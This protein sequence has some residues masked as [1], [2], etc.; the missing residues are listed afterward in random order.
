[1][2]IKIEEYN[3]HSIIQMWTLQQLDGI[4][5]SISCI[6]ILLYYYRKRPK[7]DSIYFNYLPKRDR[8]SH[9]FLPLNKHFIVGSLFKEIIPLNVI[10][11]K[12]I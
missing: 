10:D 1:M 3:A 8:Q 12:K 7:K 5:P 2:W 6:F 4:I 11:L 9:P